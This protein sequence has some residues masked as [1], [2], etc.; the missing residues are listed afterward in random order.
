MNSNNPYGYP[1]PT[2]TSLLLLAQREENKFK[3]LPQEEQDRI[4]TQREH[5]QEYKRVNVCIQQGKCPYCE[6]KLIRGKKDKRNNYKRTWKCL[7]C[8]E[9]MFN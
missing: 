3:A 4:T 6:G 7:K 8:N 1:F 5:E 9:D 2:I